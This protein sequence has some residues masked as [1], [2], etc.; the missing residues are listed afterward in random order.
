M[1][2]QT[3]LLRLTPIL[4]DVK[5][6][7]GTSCTQVSDSL[8]LSRATEGKLSGEAL[9]VG[10][11]EGALSRQLISAAATR[12]VPPVSRGNPNS[13]AP[14]RPVSVSRNGANRALNTFHYHRH[15][16]I[17]NCVYSVTR[18]SSSRLLLGRLN[19]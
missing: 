7:E 5:T 3:K 11:A 1:A 4:L 13:D 9:A 12:R 10:G 8:I 19:D 16:Y 6:A 17:S 14:P 15:D 18:C 2:A